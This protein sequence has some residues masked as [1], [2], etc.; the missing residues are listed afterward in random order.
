MNGATGIAGQRWGDGRRADGDFAREQLLDAAWRCYQ[1]YGVGK[2]T[3]EHVAREAKVS[4]TTVYR[5]F[6]N[7]NEVLNSVLLREVDVLVALLDER[8]AGAGNFGALVVAV[9]MEIPALVSNMPVFQLLMEDEAV[10]HG[11]V[12]WEEVLAAA[13]V[14]LE[15]PFAEAARRGVVREGVTLAGLSRWLVRL[16]NGYM[17]MSGDG[18]TRTESEWRSELETYLLPAIVRV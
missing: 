3:V 17:L 18:G 11:R 13:M 7:R 6:R 4:R 15:K 10:R 5:Y 12:G 16:L 8:V 14:F 1:Q 9:M 2:T